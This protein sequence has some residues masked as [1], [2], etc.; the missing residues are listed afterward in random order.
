MPDPVQTLVE[1]IAGVAA[2]LGMPV[3]VDTP[4]VLEEGSLPRVTVWT[5]T[6]ESQS[7]SRSDWAEY[8]RVSPILEVHLE[9]DDP[10]LIRGIINQAWRVLRTEIRATDWWE[11]TADGTMYSFAKSGLDVDDK[12]GIAGFAV[13]FEF[14]VELD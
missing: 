2:I 7:E 10:D 6:E 3:F 9:D 13:Q 11:Y 1:K 5:G 8:V 4:Y 14:T 12:P